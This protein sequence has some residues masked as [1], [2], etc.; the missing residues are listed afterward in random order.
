MITSIDPTDREEQSSNNA[1]NWTSEEVL[2]EINAT[3]IPEAGEPLEVEIAT[4]EGEV[5]VRQ[6]RTENQLAAKRW[7][8]NYMSNKEKDTDGEESKLALR[9]S[10]DAHHLRNFTEQG[11][12]PSDKNI[13]LKRQIDQLLEGPDV[14]PPGPL[15]KYVIRPGMAAAVTGDRLLLLGDTTE[16]EYACRTCKGKGHLGEQCSVC[17]GDLIVDGRGCS[18]CR[19]LGYGNETPAPGG[20][21]ICRKCNGSG[22]RGGVVIP[23]VAASEPITGVIVSVGPE[24][25]AMDNAA[26]RPQ[27]GDRVLHSRYAGHSIKTPEGQ[28]YRIIGSR[29]IMCLLFEV[30]R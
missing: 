4:T 9:E 26:R 13:Y 30:E 15:V 29:E 7:L 21:S 17:K 25:P 19:I 8:D 27:M 16:S 3:V 1:A 11:N 23:D 6:R 24:V 18:N 5:L 22:W 28:V 2:A 20:Y 10:P 12:V 14:V